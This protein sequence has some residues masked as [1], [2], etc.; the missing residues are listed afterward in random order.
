[1]FLF[2]AASL[3]VSA[4]PVDVRAVATAP[5]VKPPAA[6]VKAKKICRSE[7]ALGSILPRHTCRTQAEWNAMAGD[8][9][10]DAEVL[11]RAQNS[12]STGGL[13]R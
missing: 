3:L 11:R 1:M 7:V 9:K 10:D 5:A 12:R 4:A 8:S 6:D 2:L 13:V